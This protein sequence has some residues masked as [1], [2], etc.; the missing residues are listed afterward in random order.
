[1]HDDSTMTFTVTAYGKSVTITQPEDLDIHQFLDTCRTL[2]IAMEYHD[3]SWDDAII[4]AADTIWTEETQE[5]ISR[6]RAQ[7]L[8]EEEG[9]VNKQNLWVHED[10]SVR[11]YPDSDSVPLKMCDC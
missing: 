5:H 10:G 8:D 1:M 7:K 11:T 2:A 9:V 4:K 6:Y 3:E